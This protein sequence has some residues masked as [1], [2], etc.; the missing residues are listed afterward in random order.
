MDCDRQQGQF[1]GVCLSEGLL[2]CRT[3]RK[4][5][6]FLRLG[7]MPLWRRQVLGPLGLAPHVGTAVPFL[8]P[9]CHPREPPRPGNLALQEP[10][11]DNPQVGIIFINITSPIYLPNGLAGVGR[12]RRWLWSGSFRSHLGTFQGPNTH[13]P[14]TR[15]GSGRC[16]A[17]VPGLVLP[18]LEAWPVRICRLH[19]GP[20]KV[21]HCCE[22]RLPH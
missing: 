19:Q 20:E 10:K 4:G 13:P 9:P 7:P 11:H 6:S 2:G 3:G 1:H 21:F 15:G 17:T 16:S 5:P 18:G 22:R 14:W 12:R 8:P